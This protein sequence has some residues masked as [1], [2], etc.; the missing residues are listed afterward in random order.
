[1]NVEYLMEHFMVIGIITTVLV[2]AVGATFLIDCVVQYVRE[3]IMERQEEKR[4]EFMKIKN[5]HPSSKYVYIPM[6]DDMY[7]IRKSF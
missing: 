5:H 1:M 3:F 7:E 6:G 4:R 2:F